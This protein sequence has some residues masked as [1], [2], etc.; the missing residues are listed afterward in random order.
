VA[1]PLLTM[2]ALEWLAPLDRMT[3]TVVEVIVCMP[4][5]VSCA[6]FVERFGGDRELA[7]KSITLST[8]LSLLTL[9]LMLYLVQ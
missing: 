3:L 7:A 6:L 1:I 4:V 9:P 8:I 5:A 2:L